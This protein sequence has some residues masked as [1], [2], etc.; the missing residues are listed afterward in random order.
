[1]VV[2]SC[3]VHEGILDRVE[4]GVELLEYKHEP[5]TF[6]EPRR[7]FGMPVLLRQLASPACRDQ[8][9]RGDLI[10]GR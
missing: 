8:K 6:P 10:R 3:L 7:D 9:Q 2:L 4:Y 1:M 5:I